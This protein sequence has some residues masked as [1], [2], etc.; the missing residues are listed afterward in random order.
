MPTRKSFFSSLTST[1]VLVVLGGACSSDSGTDTDTT[2]SISEQ[3]DAVTIVC[4][5]DRVVI[6]TS[7][8]SSGQGGAAATPTCSLS[9]TA[10]EITLTCDDQVTSIT[11]PESVVATGGSGG[12]SSVPAPCTLRVD[13]EGVILECGDQS[14]A[15]PEEGEASA[16]CS[17]EE[18]APGY[19]TI[20]CPDGSSL[21]IVTCTHQGSS[22]EGGD[23][24]FC[25][26]TGWEFEDCEFEC[27][28]QGDSGYCRGGAGGMGGSGGAD[29]SGE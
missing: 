21:G 15:I 7:G 19:S 6:D 26:A 14:V 12:D 17:I 13:G 9:E 10:T 27:T 3:G 20:S 11:K 16:S 23:R 5:E 28:Q 24:R 4:G 29:G 1:L 2:C 8:E 18:T 25:G 22:C